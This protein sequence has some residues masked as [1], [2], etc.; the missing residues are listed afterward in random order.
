MWNEDYQ[1]I[2][3]LATSKDENERYRVTQLDSLPNHVLKMLS[4][5]KSELV[6]KGVASNI[7]TPVSAMHVLAKSPFSSVREALRE[8]N[9]VPTSVRNEI[10]AFEKTI[11]EEIDEE[12]E[13]EAGE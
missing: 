3:A 9:C 12:V 13:Y 4:N 6:Q 2:I 7:H 5:D 1:R 11:K 10:I 8:N